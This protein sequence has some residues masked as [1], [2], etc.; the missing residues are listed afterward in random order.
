MLLCADKRKVISP[1]FCIISREPNDCYIQL[2]CESNAKAPVVPHWGFDSRSQVSS[3]GHN[4][5][6][7]QGES[8]GSRPEPHPRD[9]YIIIH[10][11]I[12]NEDFSAYELSFLT[13]CLLIAGHR[14]SKTPG[15]VKA[16]TAY[17]GLAGLLTSSLSFF[18]A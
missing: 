12:L 3:S 2:S 11:R 8:Q 6:P 10:R 7:T 18:T 1:I 13:T 4:D 17:R 5:I 16:S 14:K 15:V 9:G